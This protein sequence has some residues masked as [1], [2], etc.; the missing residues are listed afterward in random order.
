VVNFTTHPSLS[1]ALLRSLGISAL[2]LKAALLGLLK[3]ISPL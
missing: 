2:N 1:A 3:R